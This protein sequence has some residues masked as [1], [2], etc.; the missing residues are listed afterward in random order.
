MPDGTWTNAA[1]S[2]ANWGTSGNWAGGIIASGAGFTAYFTSNITANQ[3]VILT[4]GV[5]PVIGTLYFSDGGV[6]GFQRYIGGST[7][8]FVTLNNLGAKPIVHCITGAWMQNASLRG[9]DG[10]RVTGTG[11]VGL[12]IQGGPHGISGEVELEKGY[13]VLGTLNSGGPGVIPSVSG[14]NWVGNT[15]AR[16][17]YYGTTTGFTETR[18]FTYTGSGGLT[19]NGASVCAQI[20][21]A[22]VTLSHASVQ[23]FPAQFTPAPTDALTMCGFSFGTNFPEAAWEFL[24]Q[25]AH[26]T[27]VTRTARFDFAHTTPK[28]SSARV[29]L[30]SLNAVSGTVGALN[31][32][33]TAATEFTGVARPANEYGTNSGAALALALGGTNTASTYSGNILHVAGSGT[34]S[35]QKDDTGTWTLSGDSTYTGAT[36]VNSGTLKVATN[37]ALGVGAITTTNGTLELVGGL[38]ISKPSQTLTLGTSG[39]V[40]LRAASGANSLAFG[41]GLLNTTAITLEVASGASL[42]LNNTV[43][44]GDGGNARGFSKTGAGLLSLANVANTFTGAIN[45]TAGTLSLPS[46]ANGGVASSWGAGSTTVSVTGTLQYTGSGHSSSRAVQLDGAA[47]VLEAVGAG[48]L[49]LSNVTQSNNASRTLTLTGTSTADNTISS[50]LSNTTGPLNIQK[51][52][53]GKW[54]LAGALNYTGTTTVTTGTFEVDAVDGNTAAGSS[55]SVAADATLQLRT[56]ASPALTNTG[57]VLGSTAVSVTGALRTGLAGVQRG[58]MRYGGNVTFNGGAVI[59]PGT[60]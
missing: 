5:Q 54:L 59:Y 13:L 47:P 8:F 32:N 31:D 44:I 17:Y 49:T 26:T 33:A 14:F 22:L 60:V 15:Y 38:T 39:G 4:T 34:L 24:P 28:T 27:N 3:G 53:A 10:F 35:V 43:A 50:A 16:L 12:Q 56:D 57:K 46:V 25:S 29:L 45:V 6:A 48:A 51:T 36:T 21:N 11:S 19:D 42:A 40:A 30:Y 2:S 9:T 37:T 52:G 1:S 55:L 7:S 18:P 41:T 20:N 23:T 58:R